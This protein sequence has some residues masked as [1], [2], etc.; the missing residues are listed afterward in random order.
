MVYLRSSQL[1]RA[2]GV[3][4]PAVHSAIGRLVPREKWLGIWI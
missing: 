1:L 3:A 2:E 4:F